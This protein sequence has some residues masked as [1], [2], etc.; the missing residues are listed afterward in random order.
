ME[1]LEGYFRSHPLPQERI[2]KLTA[3]H[4]ENHQEKPLAVRPPAP[5]ASTNDASRGT[6]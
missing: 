1:T 4:L 6:K 3:L 5:V 2:E